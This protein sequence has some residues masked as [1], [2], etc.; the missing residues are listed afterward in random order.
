M[1]LGVRASLDLLDQSV[2]IV[3]VMPDMCGATENV[4]HDLSTVSHP[5]IVDS[6]CAWSVDALS[7]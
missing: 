7:K 3:N 2:G 5:S 4:S 6:S 1:F